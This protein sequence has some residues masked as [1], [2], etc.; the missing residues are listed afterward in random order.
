MPAKRLI[1]I[2]CLLIS[3]GCGNADSF[4]RSDNGDDGADI[5]VSEAGT[6]V[7]FTYFF[8]TQLDSD[9]DLLDFAFPYPHNYSVPLFV[10]KNGTVTLFARNFPPMVLRICE[11]ASSDCDL[12]FDDL[13]IDKIDVVL[14]SCGRELDDEECG[15]G[16]DTAYTGTL[17][18]DGSLTINAISIRVRVFAVTG[19]SDGFTA[20]A[21]DT[22]LI[23]GM[24]R[25]VVK[26]TTGTVTTGDLAASGSR[27][28]AS[29]VKLVAAGIISDD[30]PTLGG[31]HYISS[32]TGTFDIDPLGL[33]K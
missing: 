28:N 14:D 3:T 7:T 13:G 20:D 6:A 5:S 16:D 31:V 12:M 4:N 21:A 33:L 24:E 15:E 25:L 1:P 22:G 17:S 27:V 19:S 11:V 9:D 10:Q 30:M 23:P 2:L 29:A 26:V 8:E 18:N 32:L